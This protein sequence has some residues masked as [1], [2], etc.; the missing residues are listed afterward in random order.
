MKFW[1]LLVIYSLVAFLW[2]AG[3][4]TIVFVIAHFLIKLW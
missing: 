1:Q 3:V 2:L 4:V